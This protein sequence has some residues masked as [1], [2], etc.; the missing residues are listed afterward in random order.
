ME[1][2]NRF[3][4][5][6][7]YPEMNKKFALIVG[8]G[9]TGSWASLFLARAGIQSLHIVDFDTFEYHNIGSQF[10]SYSDLGKDKVNAVYT[11][12]FNFTTQD[13]SVYTHNSKIEE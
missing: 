3:S 6:S 11:N 9:A 4:G 5:A 1:T 7:W 13:V 8:L 2:N 12:I 10:V